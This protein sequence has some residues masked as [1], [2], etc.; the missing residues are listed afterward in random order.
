MLVNGIDLI[1]VVNHIQPNIARHTLDL[2]WKRG[3][4]F[5]R[6]EGL[7][8]PGYLTGSGL[9][10]NLYYRESIKVTPSNMGARCVVR[11]RGMLSWQASFKVQWVP[12]LSWE[13]RD[14]G[15]ALLHLRSCSTLVVLSRPRHSKVRIHKCVEEKIIL[16][17]LTS[18]ENNVLVSNMPCSRR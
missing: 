16:S 3:G 7:L 4:E 13:G 10:C 9:W 5:W 1:T 8:G 6:W 12:T 18:L 17:W 2:L 15:L 11:R 14:S